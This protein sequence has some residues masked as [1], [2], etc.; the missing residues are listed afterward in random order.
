MNKLVRSAA[1][2]LVA[3]LSCAT[4]PAQGIVCDDTNTTD[5]E[6]V[7]FSLLEPSELIPLPHSEF[8]VRNTGPNPNRAR[9]YFDIYEVDE[10]GNEISY[11]KMVY[12][13]NTVPPGG[14]LRRFITYTPFHVSEGRHYKGVFR[15]ECDSNGSNN[16]LYGTAFHIFMDGFD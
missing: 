2:V 11:F 9:L 6:A 3:V 5:F 1:L 14:M 10:D 16:A 7:S 8:F 12:N 15:Y 4:V 13:D